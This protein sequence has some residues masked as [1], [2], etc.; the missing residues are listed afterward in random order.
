MR[1]RWLERLHRTED[2]LLASLL[3]ALLLLAVAQI[4][5]R[6]VGH[7]LDW[8]EQVSRTGVLWLALLG[9]L[10]ATRTH[11]HIA[12]DVLPRLLPPG[13]QRLVWAISQLA[14]ATIA[15]ALAWY[16]VGMV[17]LELEA[18]MPFVAGI[19]SWVPMLAVPVGFGL[20]ALRFVLASASRPHFG[21][22]GPEHDP[23]TGTATPGAEPPR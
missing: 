13:P 22:Y 17:A 20:M 7:G 21:E 4:A 19:P 5:L 3:G 18:P 23:G 6:M 2:A 14:A 8:S 11:K 12:I 9:A 1:E 16:G 10:G 15:G